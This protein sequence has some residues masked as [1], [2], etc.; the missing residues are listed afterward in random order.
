M[1]VCVITIST[2]ADNYI[3]CGWSN[4]VTENFIIINGLVMLL[5]TVQPILISLGASSAVGN[6]YVTW[7]MDYGTILYNWNM[8]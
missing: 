2:K 7:N 3:G 5:M 1:P 8:T 6:L 4:K